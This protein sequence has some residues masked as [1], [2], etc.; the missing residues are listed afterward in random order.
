MAQ[1]DL[2]PVLAKHLDR[3][4]VSPQAGRHFWC[5]V[6]HCCDL[7]AAAVQ[8]LHVAAAAPAMW[9]R[10]WAAAVQLLREVFVGC[11]K[12]RTQ[13]GDCSAKACRHAAGTAS[14]HPVELA[15]P[16]GAF[17]AHKLARICFQCTSSQGVSSLAA[18]CSCC[19]ASSLLPRRPPF[20]Q[21]FPLLEFL[22][23][24]E[25]YDAADIEKAKLQVCERALGGAAEVEQL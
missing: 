4:L 25:L 8:C 21:V 5:V 15:F 12:A 11:C 14:T 9:Q 24:R 6:V 19:F 22:G 13:S 17:S 20:A 3:H 18:A 2:T 7:P 10:V 1:Y 23:S 16:A